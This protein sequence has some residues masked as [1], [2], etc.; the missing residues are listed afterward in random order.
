MFGQPAIYMKTDI[1]R[2]V[3]FEWNL[4][5]ARMLFAPYRV[6]EDGAVRELPRG[7]ILMWGGDTAYPV[8]TADEI[9]RRVVQP[10]NEVL[11][12]A[13]APRPARV[14]L[15]IPGNH[16]WYGGLDGFG[17]MFRAPLG[18]IDR[19]SLVAGWPPSVLASRVAPASSICQLIPL[20]MVALRALIRAPDAVRAVTTQYSSRGALVLL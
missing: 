4:A 8:A 17:R 20:P 3:E 5:V 16:D 18:T 19:A 2:R 11:R 15:G 12:L 7:D 13:P 1:A 6:V 9:H 10:Y 14:L